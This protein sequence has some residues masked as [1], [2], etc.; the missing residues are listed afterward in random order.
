MSP[1]EREKE[2]A[3]DYPFLQMLEASLLPILGYPEMSDATL[4]TL[5]EILH[6]ATQ[7]WARDRD[8]DTAEALPR[9]SVHY[10][11]FDMLFIVTSRHSIG[12]FT[13]PSQIPD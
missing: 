13:L 5:A 4:Q 11:C 10:W 12:M 1:A 3:L 9:E 8:S 7:L 2:E 6:T